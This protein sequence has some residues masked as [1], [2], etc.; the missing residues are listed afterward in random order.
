MRIIIITANTLTLQGC[1]S[2]N[3]QSMNLWRR[4]SICSWDASNRRLKVPSPKVSNSK[5]SRAFDTLMLLVQ[6]PSSLLRP[7]RKVSSMD[8]FYAY[9]YSTAGWLSLQALPLL[10]SPGLI[11]TLLSPETR[12]PTGRLHT[13]RSELPALS[14]YGVRVFTMLIKHSDLEIYF[15]RSLA[16]ALLILGLLTVLLTGSIP[17]TSSIADC[18]PISKASPLLTHPC[19]SP[20]Y[21]DIRLLPHQSILSPMHSILHTQ[22]TKPRSTLRPPHSP[23]NN[24]LPHSL[25][26][27]Q[28]RPI[29]HDRTNRLR[30]QYHGVWS[31]GGDGR[32][33]FD[34]RD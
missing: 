9:T 29:Y 23:R 1:G 32:V 25:R 6:N 3:S 13:K 27:L 30:A 18:T 22:R 5:V 14:V 33:V 7:T 26:L 34:V 8:V 31:V 11:V 15:S 12:K 21:H 20:P 10:L 4:P 17:L 28:L 2:V 24:H 16:F 19:I